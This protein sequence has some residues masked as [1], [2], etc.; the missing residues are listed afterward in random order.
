MNN[1]TSLIVDD[2]NPTK[3]EDLNEVFQGLRIEQRNGELVI[4]NAEGRQVGTLSR[5]KVSYADRLKQK[6]QEKRLNE[7]QA[8]QAKQA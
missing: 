7:I 1:P 3:S 6:F 5:K 8:K 2:I 4:L